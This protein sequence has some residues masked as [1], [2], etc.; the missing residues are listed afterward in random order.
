[1]NPS[2]KKNRIDKLLI[3]RGLAPSREKAQ[4]LILTG[5][6]F[7]NSQRVD[8]AS[9]LFVEEVLI[10]VKGEDHPYVS[11]GGV[12]L[13]GALDFFQISTADKIC[14]DVGAS[15][16]GFTDCLLQSGARKVYA[17]DVGYGQFHQ[18]LREDP[19]VVLFERVNFRNWDGAGFSEKADLI[20]IDVS[21]ISLTKILPQALPFL[22]K[23]GEI[24]ALVKPQFE[25]S[26]SEAKKGVVRS[27]ALQK[28]AVLKID[29]EAKR[30]GFEI[31]GEVPSSLQGPKGNQE[32][33]LYLRNP[34]TRSQ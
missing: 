29:A 10:E 34:G 8:K 24:L 26:P 12:K 7:A 5:V 30:L 32:H 23:E 20:V 2:S 21:F 28:K 33:F 4:A 9:E 11:R 18:R 22:R 16:G 3:D 17:V 14:L 1:M 31:L 19:R 27:E 25:L 6:V 15:T 13:R